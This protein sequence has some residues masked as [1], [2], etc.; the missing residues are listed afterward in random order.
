VR[1]TSGTPLTSMLLTG[2]QVDSETA[3]YCLRARYY[4]PAIGRF[5]GRE[6]SM[7]TRRR[8]STLGP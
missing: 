1:S 8:N 5:L 4:D 3:F 6:A 7:T 2:Q